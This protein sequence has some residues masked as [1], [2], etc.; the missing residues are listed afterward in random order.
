MRQLKATSSLYKYFLALFFLILVPFTSNATNGDNLIGVGP[1]S[2]AMGGV[3]IAAPQDAISST[4]AN[5]A[6][7]CV[8]PFCPKSEFDFA[9]TLFAPK[10]DGKITVSGV[11]VK[12]RADEK[13]YLVPAFGVSA[14][15]NHKLRLGLSAYGVTGL[16]VDHR[17]SDL[18]GFLAA[19]ATQLM[20]LKVAPTVAFQVTD[21]LSVGAAIHVVNSQLD[22]N[23]GTSSAY[24]I[25]GQLG[26]LY[27]LSPSLTLG[28]TY[29]TPI[30]ANHKNVYNLDEMT[31]GSSTQDNF[32]LESPQT[33][34][35]GIA[36]EP[37]RDLLVELDGKWL[38][39][40]DAEGYDV[41]DWDDQ[42][43]LA[44]GVQYKPTQNLAL[45]IGYNYGENPV[46]D[47]TFNGDDTVKV[48]GKD[49]NAYG[50][51]T[52]RVIGFPAIVEH[53]VTVGFGYDLN[54]AVTLNFGYMH[55]FKETVTS[56][57]T[58][59]SSFGG[60]PVKLESD[61]HEDAIDFSLAW[62]F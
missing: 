58:L 12:S 3:G 30:K 6:A 34:G 53:H 40:S 49:V 17:D 62:R 31:T 16:G 38:N 20:I 10:I 27:K 18:N 43:V 61:L 22:L 15:I 59:P 52:L 51:E 44:V 7:M 54:K 13:I 11:D 5:P 50:F 46:D 26:A 47:R 9:A 57:G 39:W 1:I 23:Q 55:A 33:V 8:G 19:D 42:I 29:Q 37:L 45:R 36:Y 4:F 56:T 32:A 14:P 25:G 60:N 35:I 28:A 24:G 2:R 41:L 21:T 48:Q